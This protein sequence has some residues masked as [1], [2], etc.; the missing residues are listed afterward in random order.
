MIGNSIAYWLDK[1]DYQMNIPPHVKNTLYVIHDELYHQHDKLRQLKDIMHRQ[2][3]RRSSPLPT[4]PSTQE[5]GAESKSMSVVPTS[6]TTPHTLSSHLHPTQSRT[7]TVSTQPV[8]MKH[9]AKQ[10]PEDASPRRREKSSYPP[11]QSTHKRGG[12]IQAKTSHSSYEVDK[13]VHIQL[14]MAFSQTTN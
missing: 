9:T 13:A 11:S 1:L 5:R 14:F 2:E 3:I 6:S 8:S 7:V 4:I 12:G 10:P